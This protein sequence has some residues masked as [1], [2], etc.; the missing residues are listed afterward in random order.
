MTQRIDYVALGQTRYARTL[1]RAVNDEHALIVRVA[2]RP[3]ERTPSPFFRALA[4]A[5]RWLWDSGGSRL[6]TRAA[7][8]ALGAI[9][10]V[11]MYHT[12]VH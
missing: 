6:S 7:L 1:R 9:A 3:L 8:G 12:F 10:A 2:R 5:E 4:H 11:I